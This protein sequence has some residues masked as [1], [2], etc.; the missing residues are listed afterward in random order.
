[1]KKWSERENSDRIARLEKQNR[2]LKV[3]L[4]LLA[5]PLLA[6]L[7]IGA[8]PSTTI[9][10]SK[11]IIP[12]VNGQYVLRFETDGG[13]RLAELWSR[14][15]GSA[16]W[17]YDG[18]DKL[19][20]SIGGGSRG[21]GY[22]SIKNTNGKPGVHITGH[23]VAVMGALD[24]GDGSYGALV[25]MTLYPEEMNNP[26]GRGIIEVHDKSGKAG[27]MLSMKDGQPRI[28]LCDRDG[29]VIFET[30]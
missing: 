8:T 6:V 21:G 7:V 1:M 26:E 15:G 10:A 16:L 25:S 13:Q 18:H 22:V 4:G 19:A 29:N 11:I 9:T 28:V 12:N 2:H 23:T 3:L 20:A 5:L 27:A 17:F 30:P 24:R 14:G